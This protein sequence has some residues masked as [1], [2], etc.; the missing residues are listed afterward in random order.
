MSEKGK[1]YRIRTLEEDEYLGELLK[2]L[3]EEADEVVD[4]N[5]DIAELADVLEVLHAICLAKGSTLDDLER[6]R[7][8]KRARRGGFQKRIFLIDGEP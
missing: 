2:K 7:A 6:I 4:S 3:Y 1:A 5:G 8:D